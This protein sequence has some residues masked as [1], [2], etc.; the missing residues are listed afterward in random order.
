M[1]SDYLTI[2]SSPAEENCAQVG[3]DG[4]SEQS[5]KECRAFVNQLTRQFGTP[6]EGARFAVKSFPHDFGSY[7]EVCVVYNDNIEEAIEFAY[8]VERESP[9][10]WDDEARKELGLVGS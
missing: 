4:Y 8:K 3:K 7:K 10:Q 5:Q 9:A 1:A 6:P 2:G